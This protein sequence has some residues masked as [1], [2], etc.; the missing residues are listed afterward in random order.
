MPPALMLQ[1]PPQQS[2]GDAQV[3][4]FCWQNEGE[5]HWPLD[6]QNPEQQLE[7]A[8]HGL[9]L[10]LH[11][12]LS[13][14]QVPDPHSPLQHCAFPEQPAPSAVHAGKAHAPPVHVLLQQSE[15]FEHAPPR[16]RQVAPA[17]GGR[18]GPPLDEEP[19]P[20]EAPPPEEAPLEAP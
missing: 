5:A 1:T 9:P 10:V 15:G 2:D 20:D 19:P 7:P 14:V 8:E 12:V 17:S 18:N 11:D 3:S 4:P 16:L 6:G 13:G